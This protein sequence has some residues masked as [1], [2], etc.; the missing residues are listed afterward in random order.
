MSVRLARSVV[1][2]GASAVVATGC[3]TSR[4]KLAVLRVHAQ[5]PTEL[6]TLLRR[7]VRTPK[8]CHLTK[9]V[10]L[11]RWGYTL[12]KGPLRAIFDSNK[13]NARVALSKGVFH[14]GWWNVKVLW[15]EPSAS[16]RGWLLVRGV[17]VDGSAVGFV[18]GSPRLQTALELHAT[19]PEVSW[20]TG[21]LLPGSGCYAYQ[22]DGRSF[23]YSIIVRAYR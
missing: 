8:R 7:P 1:I 21:T 14:D 23:S 17:G 11:K 20:T 9:P 10:K 12:G 16:Y 15:F 22:V 13:D 18:G 19:D 6:A 2:I 5:T 4:A 3:G